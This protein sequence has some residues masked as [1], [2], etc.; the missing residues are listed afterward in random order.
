LKPKVFLKNVGINILS[1]I[2]RQ[3]FIKKS[4]T[5]CFVETKNTEKIEQFFFKKT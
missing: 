4:G 3:K 2:F 1:K 5:K